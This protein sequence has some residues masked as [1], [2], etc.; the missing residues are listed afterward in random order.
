MKLYFL[1]NHDIIYDN[2]LF[3]CF[4][5]SSVVGVFL[6]SVIVGT[7]VVFVVAVSQ[8]ISFANFDFL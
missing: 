1:S 8:S 4:S 5:N 3:S 7:V 6:F 2:G